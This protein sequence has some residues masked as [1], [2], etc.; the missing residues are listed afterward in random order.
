MNLL[1][2]RNN[3]AFNFLLALANI[4]SIEYIS[5]D[6]VAIFSLNPQL[7]QNKLFRYQFIFLY[8]LLFGQLVLNFSER[9]LDMVSNKLI[10]LSCAFISI[11]IIILIIITLCR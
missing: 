2:L 8:L 1:T 11:L 9:A 5:A 10:H 4:Q 3:F 6:L 7:F